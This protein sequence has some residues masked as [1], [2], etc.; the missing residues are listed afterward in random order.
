[1]S[2][3]QVSRIESGRAPW[4]RVDQAGRLAAVVG[5]ELAVRLYPR[6]EP[7]RDAAHLR[8]LERLRAR[9]GPMWRWRTEVPLPLPGDRR[10]WDAVVSRA[11][12]VIAIEAETKL[13]DIQA[14]ER[15]LA[16]K[17][18][19]GGIDRVVLLVARTARNQ[20]A[21]RAAGAGLIAAFPI[22]ARTVLRALEE[23]DDIGGC[24]VVV[25]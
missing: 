10:A 14:L 25:L 11:G 3:P 1:M 19:D 2:H 22:R 21:I 6:G 23:G 15:R 12:I 20:E 9:I 8:L 24:A 7:I 5:L 17:R 18:R 13:T 16:L 4:L